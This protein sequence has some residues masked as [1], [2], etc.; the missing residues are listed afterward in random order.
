ML[1]LQVAEPWADFKGPCGERSDAS[2]GN[3]ASPSA[4]RYPRGGQRCSRLKQ[5]GSDNP[6]RFAENVI[7]ISVLC[8]LSDQTLKR[9]LVFGSAIG[10]NTSA[11][12]RKFE[13]ATGMEP[14]AYEFAERRHVTVIRFDIAKY[15]GNSVLVYFCY[16][17]A[18][19]DDGER[20]GW[21]ST[22]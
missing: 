19:E 15:I 18:H 22:Q 20:A 9:A 12:P 13:P 1:R 5:L 3:I 14:K 11:S 2:N 6:W 4:D 7:G 10:E 8:H 16:P 17:Q 21:S